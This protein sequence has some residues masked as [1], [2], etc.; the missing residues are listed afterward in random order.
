M[1]GAAVVAAALRGMRIT[2]EGNPPSPIQLQDGLEQLNMVMKSIA[3][4]PQGMKLWTYM[5]VTVPLVAGK[6]TY[7]IGP[8][9]ADVISP[10]PLR[11]FEYGNIYRQVM[12][13]Q[14]FDTP[15]RLISRTEY[16]MFG[17]KNS[18]GQPNAIYY[19][20]GINLLVPGT[21]QSGFGTLFV[22]NPLS[23]TATGSILL[24]CQRAIYD[25]AQVD[26]FESVDFP[27]EWFTFLK[28][29]LMAE[30]GDEFEIP[31]ERLMRYMKMAEQAGEA[32]ADFSVEEAPVTFGIDYT[33]AR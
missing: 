32:C 5:T 2:I 10:R 14:F 3:A 21:S 16:A 25:L 9:T 17:S 11:V 4:S 18:P 7:T 20:P 29:K 28:W 31:E 26:G 27:S 6:T 13:G 22:Y 19:L 24:N 12:N 15:L 30:W 23:T 33:G 8:V 1:N